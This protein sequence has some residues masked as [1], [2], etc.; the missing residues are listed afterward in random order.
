[1]GPGRRRTHDRRL[2]GKSP[3]VLSGVT[4]LVYTAARVLLPSSLLRRPTHSRW[5][6]TLALLVTVLFPVQAA[7]GPRGGQ[8]APRGPIT[9]MRAEHRRLTF[10]KEIERLAV[11]DPSILSA[12][13]VSSRE[14]LVLGRDTGR[15]SLIL[16]F[17][18]G[19]IDENTVAVVRDLAVLERAL[20]L[21]HPSIAVEGAPDRD[22][23]V[24]TG[25]VPDAA[26]SQAAEAVAREYLGAGAARGTN[27]QVYLGTPG[28]PAD[29][30]GASAPQAQGQGAAAPPAAQ[31]T[32]PVAGS[33]VIINLIQLDQL[34]ATPEAKL[35]SA[36][37]QMGGEHVRIRRIQ[38][39][40][41]RD[42]ARDT[43]V[44]EGKVPTQVALTRI[45]T[46]AA[47]LFAG[48]TLSEEDIRVVADEAG[49]LAG[50]G[51]NQ[52]Q[53]QGGQ[54]QM[55]GGG[56]T[57]SMFGGG[58]TTRLTNQVRTNLGRAKAVEVARGRILSFIEVQ[59]LPQVRVDI[60][61]QEINRSR[62]RS[63]SPSTAVLLSSFRQP[64]LNPA[65][66]ATTV[67]G[68]QAAR[69]GSFGAA[70]QNVLSFLNGTFTN[71][72]QYSGNRFAIDA[73]LSLLERE[74]I[75]RSLSS[76]SIT[77]LSGESASVQVGGEVPVPVAFAP[78]FGGGAAAGGAGGGAGGAGAAAT[79]GV[80]SSVEFVPFG[81]QL[82]VR[83]LVGDDNSITLDLQPIIVTPDAVLTD[84]IRQTT[85]AAVATTA[86]QTRA[87]RTSSRL[88]DGQAL[89]VGGLVSG[90]TSRNA[91]GIPWVRNVPLLGSL[92]Q[93]TNR[94]E[95]Q[96][97]LLILVNPVV[98][99]PPLPGAGL[100]AYPDARGAL[101][102]TTASDRSPT[103]A[104]TPPQ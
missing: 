18:D 43:L 2:P 70:V 96:T 93:G 82:Q 74:G 52:G 39:G 10:T 86:F 7:Q 103:T 64:S 31:V 17:D 30:G 79:P 80:F 22:A 98:V 27:A 104:V 72:I 97:E 78:A 87:L 61:L 5:L 67:Q 28:P 99:R 62:L 14:V 85:G 94:N 102:A 23:L 40:D 1:M 3:I 21:L 65:Q 60:R 42:D 69:V 84:T 75:A 35:Q 68:D 8:A 44:L 48:Q 89:L 41:V 26:V 6:L 36:I 50:Q 45:L 49:A 101:P 66:S 16:W 59:D 92:V 56:A 55:G 63:F 91:S 54:N 25:R 33:A 90:N 76:P 95:Q 53:Q 11:G 58:R 83:P 88:S 38:R 12:E 77:V 46:V 57:A 47:Q 37:A 4:G 51:M 34:P 29:A 15:T 81:V 20:R 24:L 13:L 73:A 71:Q 100:W 19:T 32:G 9:V